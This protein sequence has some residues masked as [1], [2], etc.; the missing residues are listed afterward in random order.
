MALT[1]CPECG[2][3]VSD[4]ATSCPN[5]GYPLGGTPTSDKSAADRSNNDIAG[6]GRFSHEPAWRRV[7]IHWDPIGDAVVIS[8]ADRSMLGVTR[9]Q[10]LIVTGDGSGSYELQ[11]TRGHVKPI[12]FT[13][14]NDAEFRRAVPAVGA[15]AAIDRTVATSGEVVA[16]PAVELGIRFTRTVAGFV[17]GSAAAFGLA[18]LLY[19]AAGT[20]YPVYLEDPIVG[21]ELYPMAA[22]ADGAYGLAALLLIISVVLFLIWFYKAYKAASALGP[23][24]TKWSPGWSIGGWFIPFANL[25]IPKLVMN[26]IDRVSNPA[27]GEP[28][29]GNAWDGGPRLATSDLW[30][31]AWLLGNIATGIEASLAENSGGGWI[32]VW[33]ATGAG[34]LA[35]AGVM[36]G[37]TTLTIGRRFDDPGPG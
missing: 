18:A 7:T 12:Q 6:S 30:W 16:T 24:G 19:L 29:I 21:A 31:A 3:Q 11:R 1:A 34:L 13:P 32:A 23:T 37:W 35:I 22:A 4:Q 9:V 8:D 5:C 25:V 20:D 14:D 33:A 2:H 17:Y 27:N 10:D 26:E 28:P 36:L 15:G